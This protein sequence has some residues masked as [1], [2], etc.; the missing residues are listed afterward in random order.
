MACLGSLDQTCQFVTLNLDQCPPGLHFN[1]K[2]KNAR[3]LLRLLRPVIGKCGVRWP[4][5]TQAHVRQHG[6]LNLHRAQSY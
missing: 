2:Y 4:L 5:L 3:Q 1:L 6:L